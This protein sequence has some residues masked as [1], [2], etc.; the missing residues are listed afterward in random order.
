M[1]TNVTN[2]SKPGKKVEVIT[3]C[4]PLLPHSRKCGSVWR[5]FS[6]C[7]ASMITSRWSVL[8]SAAALAAASAKP[9]N[10]EAASTTALC[11]ERSLRWR[12]TN[13]VCLVDIDRSWYRTA[14]TRTGRVKSARLAAC[15]DAEKFCVS[16]VV[17]LGLGE[18]TDNASRCRKKS[19][20]TNK[21]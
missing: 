15:C 5:R 9:R 18:L 21:V 11:G 16:T 20:R 17:T 7:Y 10:R 3:A 12:V 14:E 2:Y 1:E 13:F 6:K 8:P 4:A 19:P